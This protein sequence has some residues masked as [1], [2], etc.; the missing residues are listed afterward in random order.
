MR[1][2]KPLVRRKASTS[3]MA[4]GA[5]CRAPL[6]RKNSVP[7]TLSACAAPRSWASSSTPVASGTARVLGLEHVDRGLLL[8][9]LDVLRQQLDGPLG[10]VALAPAHR[11]IVLHHRAQF[12]DPVHQRLRARRA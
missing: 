1:S 10:A 3:R 12:Q 4:P 11:R 5:T 2:R 7:T 9:A 8:E 6:L